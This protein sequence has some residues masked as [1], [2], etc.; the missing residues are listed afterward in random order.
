MRR[1]NKKALNKKRNAKK[2]VGQFKVN[3]FKVLFFALIM[4]LTIG[5][6]AFA[7]QDIGAMITNWFNNEKAQS[8]S[9]LDQQINA[10]GELLINSLVKDVQTE[11]VTTQ[12]N[13][14]QYT[15]DEAD[16][17]IVELRRYAAELKEKIKAEN[18][19][20]E[21]EVTLYLDGV[22]EEAISQLN[23]Y[24]STVQP[25]VAEPAPVPSPTP[26]EPTEGVEDPVEPVTTLESTTEPEP[27]VEPVTEPEPTEQPE[28]TPEPVLE[29]IIE[30]VP[31][32][33]TEVVEEDVVVEPNVNE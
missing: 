9:K 31:E 6:I 1:K 3:K 13:L 19:G 17:R 7:N 33:V 27:V 26:T 8:Y 23:Y 30:P 4:S 22:L 20:K 15:N 12:N 28:P 11:M 2:N 10:E 29:P 32:P 21:S 18:G 25:I 24:A 16:K 14:N 5:N